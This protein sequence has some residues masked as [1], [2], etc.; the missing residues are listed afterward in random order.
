MEGGLRSRK[1]DKTNMTL[2]QPARL[3]ILGRFWLN[4]NEPSQCTENRPWPAET[5]QKAGDLIR[6]SSEF[7]DRSF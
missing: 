2:V 4:I 3:N 7:G 6:E 5:V 1:W